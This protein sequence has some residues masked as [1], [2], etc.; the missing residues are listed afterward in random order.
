M[1]RNR[2]IHTPS[3]LHKAWRCT[4][5]ERVEIVKTPPKGTAV[6]TECLG[7]RAI[8]RLAS[9]VWVRAVS[10]GAQQPRLRSQ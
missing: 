3:T 4:L 7:M 5:V 9:G 2:S 10:R 8:R 6:Y 1:P